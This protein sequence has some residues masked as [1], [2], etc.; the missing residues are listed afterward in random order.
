MGPVLPW[1]MPTQTTR[2]SRFDRILDGLESIEGVLA[3]LQALGSSEKDSH[4]ET[5]R[6]QWLSEHMDRSFS[7][8]P[9]RSDLPS[10]M[11]VAFSKGL[12]YVAQVYGCPLRTQRPPR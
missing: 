11:E 2:I 12:H 8:K 3:V 9:E 7:K 10:I 6:D 5:R 4:P 1:L